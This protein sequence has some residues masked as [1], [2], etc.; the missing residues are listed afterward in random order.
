MMLVGGLGIIVLAVAILPMLG[1]G[2]TQLFKAETAGPMK[3]QKFTP[4]I[5]DTARAIWVSYGALA[6]GCTVSYHAAGMSWTDALLHMC[7]TISLGGFSRYDASFGHWNSPPQIEPCPSSSCCCPA[8][9]W[10]CTSYRGAR[11]RWLPCCA[12]P[13]R[14]P[15]WACCWPASR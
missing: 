2:G 3:D 7:T 8:S 14:R 6:L 1:V 15:L 12:T 10:C 13:R 9:T 5:A 4:R 11:A